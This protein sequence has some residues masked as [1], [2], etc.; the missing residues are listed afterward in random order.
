MDPGTENPGRRYGR[1]KSALKSGKLPKYA[2]EIIDEQAAA[3]GH[4][5]IVARPI[6]P[7]LIT[8]HAGWR[9][10]TVPAVSVAIATAATT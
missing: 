9:F 6:G 10:E 2:A 3:G 8:R 5:A 1:T 7:C 4:A